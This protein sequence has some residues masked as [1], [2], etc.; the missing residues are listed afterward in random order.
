LIWF[1][2]F[3]GERDIG[4]F[5]SLREQSVEKTGRERESTDTEQWLG[6]APALVQFIPQ[7]LFLVHEWGNRAMNGQVEKQ[8][9]V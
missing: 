7:L 3:R 1:G 2:F 9:S 4:M 6:K 8:A 5:I